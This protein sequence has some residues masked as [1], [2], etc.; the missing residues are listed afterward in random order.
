MTQRVCNVPECTF[1]QTGACMNSYQPE[2]CPSH[3]VALALLRE[4]NS[5]SAQHGV[6]EVDNALFAANNADDIAGN[7][8]LTAPDEKPSLPRSGTLGLRETD[9]LMTNR[10]VNMVGIVGL[11]NAGKTA[12]IAS[13][14]LLLAHSSLSGF[15]YAGSKTLMAFEEI[16]RGSRR[17]NDGN[18]PKE[19]TLH[20]EVADDRQAGFL[21]LRLRRDRDGQKFDLLM[22]DVPGEWSRSLISSGDAE[23]FAF[24]KAV[25]VVWLMANGVDF[26]ESRTRE[27]AIH[28]MTN[29]IERLA[30]VLPFPRPKTILVAT[31]HDK[32]E[33]PKVAL[34][35]IQEYAAQFGFLI[36]FT[37]IASFSETSVPPGYGLAELIEKTISVSNTRPDPWP[38]THATA[39]H[40]AFLKFGLP[41]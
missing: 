33:F 29:L 13:L 32:G 2:D 39:A 17:W 20:T 23:R 10:Y 30:V 9:A 7:A 5:E 22:P 21:H 26:L 6:G 36:D 27:L 18:P 24:L 40:R 1:P 34:I 12:C 31:W 38:V 16:S 4:D 19:M 35:R 14:Y 41:L 3:Q 25:E 37:P 15:R 28:R 11:P 8:V